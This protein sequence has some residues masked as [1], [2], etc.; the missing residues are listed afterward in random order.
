MLHLFIYICL[1]MKR[2]LL[3]HFVRLRYLRDTEDVIYLVLKPPENNI[4]FVHEDYKILSSTV[5][6]P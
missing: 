6:H 3:F 4:K 1:I 5:L 2:L